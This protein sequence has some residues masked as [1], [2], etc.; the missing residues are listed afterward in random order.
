MQIAN[1][2]TKTKVSKD[3]GGVSF[4][5]YTKVYRKVDSLGTMDSVRG[6]IYNI[7]ITDL[8]D[9]LWFSYQYYGYWKQKDKDIVWVYSDID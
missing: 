9:S 6:N 8:N 4:I 7:A 3:S 5:N 2:A 1:Q